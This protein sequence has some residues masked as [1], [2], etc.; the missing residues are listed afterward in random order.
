MSMDD[1]LPTQS[2]QEGTRLLR[3]FQNVARDVEEFKKG[4]SSATMDQRVGDNFGGFSLPHHERLLDNMDIKEDNKLEVEEEIMGRIL[5]LAK[6]TMVA[7]KI[8]DG[9]QEKDNI[10]FYSCQYQ[11]PNCHLIIV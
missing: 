3:Q 7:T 5:M 11:N 6:H 4:K 9:R 2:D 8:K 10:T 1:Y